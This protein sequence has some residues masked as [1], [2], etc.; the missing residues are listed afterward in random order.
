MALVIAR[1]IVPAASWAGRI[2]PRPVAP[3]LLDP[4][5]GEARMDERIDER[6]HDRLEFPLSRRTF[7]GSIMAAG[8]A[9][10][11]GQSTA[12]GEAVAPIQGGLTTN[13]QPHALPADPR[14]TLLDFLREHAGLTGTKKGCDH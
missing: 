13:G 11:A 9:V 10:T 4:R 7:M 5:A 1:P 3:R 6:I 8:M 14:V 12:R 2:R